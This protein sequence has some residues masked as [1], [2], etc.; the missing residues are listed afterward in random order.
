MET[1]TLPSYLAKLDECQLPPAV[2]PLGSPVL[3]VAAAG[4]GKTTLYTSRIQWLLDQGLNPRSIVAITFTNKAAAE[5][6]HRLG[7]GDD[8]KVGPRISTIHSLALNAIRVNP[9][10]FGLSDKIS[11]LDDGESGDVIRRVLDI[12]KKETRFESYNPWRVKEK[13]QY[14]RARGI[15]FVED[16]TPAVHAL[17]LNDHSG[18]LAMDE[19]ELELWVEYTKVKTQGSLIDFDDMLHLV[20]QRGQ[21][22]LVWLGKIQ[23][24][25]KTVLVDEAQDCSRVQW[26]F[27]NLLMGPDN[28]NL[29]AVG[30][31]SQS[32]FLFNGAS[33]EILGGMVQEW[34]SVVPTLYKLENNYRSTGSV[35]RFANKIQQHMVDT[36]PLIMIPKREA[37]DPTLKGRVAL[38]RSDIGRSVA[39][40]IAE[41]IA[42]DNIN[43]TGKFK[44]KDNAILVRSASQIPDIE[45]ELVRRRIPY[46]IRGGISLFQTHEAKDVLSFLKLIVNPG[47]VIAFAR[48]IGLPK[49]GIGD[50]HVERVRRVAEK[51]FGG[52]IIKACCSSG[53]MTLQPF[54]NLIVE[55]AALANPVDIFDKVLRDIR[56][57]DLVRER[58]K[59][60]KKDDEY[61]CSRFAILDKVREAIDVLACAPGITTAADVIFRITLNGK[62]EAEKEGG[63]TIISTIHGA[64]GL[65]WPRVFVTNLYEGSIPHLWSR[66][67]KEVEEERR[68]FYVA[69]TRAREDVYLCVPEMIQRG[70]NTVKVSP[71]RFLIE[72]NAIPPC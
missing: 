63:V 35:V 54:G 50:A 24:Q 61:V 57:K 55:L 51:D 47:D 25:F 28:F 12:K 2:H 7:Y 21:T 6:R 65:E 66:T 67:E 43:K 62:D 42:R 27:V 33:P 59:K 9:R 18:H 52:D 60:D 11:P 1:I 13:I 30:D 4:S 58:C 20:I 45:G 53:H 68:L 34:K 5:I 26:A 17:A 14:H 70:P 32:I 44:Y 49:R 19:Q 16:Y 48:A 10:G 38:I 56:Y 3:V 29:M 39:F 71:S 23:N 15:G 41:M 22:D 8:P 64:K 31:L 46:I 37:A 69:V 72:V 40:N 36:V